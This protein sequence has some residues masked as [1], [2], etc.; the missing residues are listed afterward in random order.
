M[1]P[2]LLPSRMCQGKEA[3]AA[4]SEGASIAATTTKATTAKKAAG[5]TA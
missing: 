4:T 5:R 1:L 2:S 3:T